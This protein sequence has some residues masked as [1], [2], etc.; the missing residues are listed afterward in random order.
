M[1][2]RASPA[3][4]PGSVF[5]RIWVIVVRI[6][7]GRVATYGQVARLAGLSGGAR[8]AGWALHALPAEFRVDGRP[9]PWHRVINARG[10][11][12]SRPGGEVDVA[13]AHQR[14]RLVREGVRFNQAGM[15]DL[16]RYRWSGTLPR[17]LR[18]ARRRSSRRAGG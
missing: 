15:I 8:T 10:G 1:G 3:G 5:G 13:S 18:P 6:P 4:S 17:R 9:V 2:K 7:R 16:S 12:S 14:A 11:I